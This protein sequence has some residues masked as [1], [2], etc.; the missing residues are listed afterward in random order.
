MKWGVPD[1]VP[2]DKLNRIIWHEI[3]G[4]DA[5]YPAAANA[6]FSPYFTEGDDDEA[7]EKGAGDNDDDDDDD[8]N[9]EGSGKRAI[10]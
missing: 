5:P 4:W 10:P 8:D 3:K 2:T 9:D 7:E 1:A 6:V